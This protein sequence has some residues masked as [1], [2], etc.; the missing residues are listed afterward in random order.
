MLLTNVGLPPSFTPSSLCIRRGL[1]QT[2]AHLISDI[3]IFR[4]AWPENQ[5]LIAI[6]GSNAK[7]TV[8]SM[9]AEILKADGRHVLVGG[10][11]GPQ[12]LDLLAERTDESVAVLELSSFQLER[13]R[14]L[15]F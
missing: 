11:L 9:V 6:T 8:T 12:A 14:R 4:R 2:S 13:T 5:P 7:S 3:Q 1:E 10:N 15:E